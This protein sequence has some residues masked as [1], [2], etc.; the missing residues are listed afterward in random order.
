[1]GVIRD[2]F[3]GIFGG[4][5]EPARSETRCPTI[6][7]DLKRVFKP[8]L[9]ASSLDI[10]LD[11]SGIHKKPDYQQQIANNTR[12]IADRLRELSEERTR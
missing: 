12:E 11:K 6:K 9:E 2:F 8:V 1:M 10:F 3:R 5:T 4:R 7:D